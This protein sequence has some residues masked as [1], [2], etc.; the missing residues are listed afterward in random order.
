MALVN[1]PTTAAGQAASACRREAENMVRMV[2]A[3]LDLMA[4]AIKK[5]GGR[6]AVAAAL[7][8]ADAGDLA[9]VW[10]KAK[11]LV[12]AADPTAAPPDLPA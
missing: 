4:R 9:T 10:Q 1:T 8:T 5:G 12:Q 6:A 2:S 11:A 7:G 3:S